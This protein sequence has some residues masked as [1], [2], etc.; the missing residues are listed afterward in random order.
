MELCIYFDVYANLLTL[1]EKLFDASEMF[2]F[3]FCIKF[4]K[5][6]YEKDS[7]AV[8]DESDRFSF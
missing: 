5:A 7:K 2:Q 3:I 6:S 4:N 1:A 8:L